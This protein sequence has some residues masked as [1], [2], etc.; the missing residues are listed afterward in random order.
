LRSRDGEER[1]CPEDECERECGC[2]KS[3]LEAILSARLSALVAAREAMLDGEEDNG[4]AFE[5]GGGG[6]V[7]LLMAI[8]GEGAPLL[9]VVGVLAVGERGY[10]AA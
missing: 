7:I 10:S 9:L 8:E 5:L 4:G 1:E 6:K 2:P 3:F